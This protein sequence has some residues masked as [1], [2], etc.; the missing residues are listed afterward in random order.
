MINFTE[1][2]NFEN[3]NQNII[4]LNLEETQFQNSKKVNQEENLLKNSRKVNREEK[5]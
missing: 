1:I 4:K 5:Q 3:F 2:I